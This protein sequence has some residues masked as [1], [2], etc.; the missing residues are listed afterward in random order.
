MAGKGQKSLGARERYLNI[1][2]A[3]RVK[4]TDILKGKAILLVDDI[5]TTGATINECARV[6]MEAG[7]R[8]V[9]SLTLAR[10][11]DSVMA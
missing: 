4:K 6:L 3:F 5:F 2:G 1:L 9:S 7:A 10:A 11:V 8:E